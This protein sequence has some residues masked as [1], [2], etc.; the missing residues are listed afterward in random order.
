[1]VHSLLSSQEVGV[2]VH[3][4]WTQASSVQGLPSLHWV[5]LVQE[6][7]MLMHQPP[8]MVPASTDSSST[9]KRRQEPLGLMPVNTE[10][11][12]PPEGAGAGAGQ[13]SVPVP[14]LTLV[15]RN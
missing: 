14:G 4:P 5:S 1:M 9:L 3:C 6:I 7:R 12:D 13:A 15:G 8:P 10:R 2:D 11:A